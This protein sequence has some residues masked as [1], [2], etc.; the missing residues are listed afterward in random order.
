MITCTDTRE[1]FYA[2]LDSEL[3]GTPATDKLLI[4]GDFNARVDRDG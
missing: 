4:L 3:S 1:Q 2:D